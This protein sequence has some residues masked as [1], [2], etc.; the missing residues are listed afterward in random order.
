[1]EERYTPHD[2]CYRSLHT[3]LLPQRGIPTHWMIITAIW[4]KK[5]KKK[6]KKLKLLSDLTERTQHR[7]QDSA[8]KSSTTSLDFKAQ[9]SGHVYVLNQRTPKINRRKIITKTNY[10]Q[11]NMIP[12]LI[13]IFQTVEILTWK[14]CRRAGTS[15]G[16]S[17]GWRGWTTEWRGQN[18]LRNQLSQWSTPGTPVRLKTV[19]HYTLGQTDERRE[20]WKDKSTWI[21]NQE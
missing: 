19:S 21:W 17:R 8:T 2:T 1:M 7:L 20:R 13:W 12:R 16:K 14:P 15:R 10:N 3:H 6:E 18:P 9:L 4:T 5:I 11:S